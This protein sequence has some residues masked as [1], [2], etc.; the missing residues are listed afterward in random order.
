MNPRVEKLLKLPLYQRILILV[1]L[2][3]VVVALFVYLLYLPKQ[4]ELRSLQ[5][6]SET[7]ESKLQEDRRIANNLPKFK[8]EFEK[9]SEQLQAALTQLPN[10]K[11]IPSLLSSIASLANDQ[12]LEVLRFKPGKEVSRGFYADVP[13]ELKLVGS[14]HQVASFFYEVGQLPRIVNIGNVKLSSGK[15]ELLSVDCMA[16]TFRFVEQPPAESAKKKRK[17]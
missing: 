7:L 5:E 17:K 10:Q 16:T 14:F 3:A 6:K 1:G 13:V 12:G 2:V 15:G 8:A 11:E 4:E 9:M